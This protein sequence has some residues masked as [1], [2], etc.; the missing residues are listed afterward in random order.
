MIDEFPL[1]PDLPEEAEKEAV[2]LIESF[3]EQLVKAAKEAISHLYTDIMPYIKSDSW[4][5]FRNQIMDGYKNYSN[6]IIQA[7]YDFKEIRAAIF[8]QYKNEIL[9]DLN[10]DLVEENNKLRE[11]I[12]RLNEALDTYRRP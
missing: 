1:Y 9:P 7:D 6:R 4:Q 2:A 3:K 8:K 5:N 11:D 10:Q 12:K